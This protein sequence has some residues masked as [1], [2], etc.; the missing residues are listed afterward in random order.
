VT[1][2]TWLLRVS[3][4]GP[5]GEGKGRGDQPGLS[6]HFGQ[7]KL[8]SER[9]KQGCWRGQHPPLTSTAK[10]CRKEGHLFLLARTRKEVMT[11]HTTPSFLEAAHAPLQHLRVPLILRAGRVRRRSAEVALVSARVR[12]PW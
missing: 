6:S 2:K 8:A 7:N 11:I 4:Y 5:K 9:T 1:F 3:V 10:H 12:G